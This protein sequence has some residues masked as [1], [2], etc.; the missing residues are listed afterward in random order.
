MVDEAAG[1]V[2]QLGA[3]IGW[4]VPDVDDIVVCLRIQ[5]GEQQRWCPTSA[6]DRPGAV[7]VVLCC[8]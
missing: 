5:V 6:V 3:S 8:E 2:S 1:H 7:L 4:T